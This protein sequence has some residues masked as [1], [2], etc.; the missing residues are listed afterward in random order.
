MAREIHDD[1]GSSLTA[2]GLI[3]E[4]LQRQ[5]EFRN[6]PHIEKISVSTREMIARTNE[7]I[8]A[9]NT[10]NDTLGSLLAHTRK[11]ATE[12]L[13]PAG[14]AFVYQEEGGQQ[15][16][17]IGNM[18][19]RNIYLTVKE[20]LHNVVK[21]SG[22]ANVEITIAVKNN[23]LHIAITDDGNGATA[24][25]SGNGLGLRNMNRRMNEIGG[26]WQLIPGKGTKILLSC[27]LNTT[28]G[29]SS[30]S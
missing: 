9:V 26:T 28:T 27:P 7:I 30:L 17:P 5:P 2:M 15:D 29:E 19:R 23:R 8:W 11:L 12:F 10:S 20:A 1:L 3:T 14:I 22:A 24:N 25:T 6:N 13:Q 16:Q 4:L 21:H 18:M